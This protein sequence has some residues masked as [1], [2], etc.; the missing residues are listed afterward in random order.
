[1]KKFFKKSLFISAFLLVCGMVQAQS[2]TG[3]VSD[4]AGP[5]P[6]VNVAVKNSKIGTTTDLDGKFT[7]NNLPK[8]AVLSISYLGYTTQI[9]TVNSQTIIDVTL[10]SDNVDL[11][12]VVVV[13]FGTT[14]KKD[15]TGAIAVVSAKEFEGRANTGIGNALEGKVA[16]VQ[17][18]KP[19]GQPQAGY[20]IR[21]RGTSTITAG[22]E[23]LYILDGIPTTSISEIS[24]SD[25][26]TMTVLKD[27]SSAAIYGA[28]G[29]NGVILITTKRGG[30]QKTKVTLDTYVSSATVS[31]KLD[32]LD[33]TQYKA[34]M[35]EMGQTTDWSKYPYN[36]NWQDRVLRTAVS[37]NYALGVSGGDEKT[38]YYLSGTSD[39]DYYP[40]VV[41]ANSFLYSRSTTSDQVYLG[42]FNGNPALKLPFNESGADFSD[43]Y[44][45][46]S[47]TI[48]LS[49]TKSG[50]RGE[51]DLYLADKISGKKWSLNLYN[52]YINSVNNEL[53][54]CYS[55]L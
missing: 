14:K 34:L 9:I 51:Y 24:P 25:I 32:V 38:N 49:S 43:A 13:G 33:A 3:K 2:V 48:L 15:V 36:N 54:G 18:T 21:V 17:I 47:H 50:G 29:S 55:P 39:N 44:P 40:I 27:A 19:S 26:E 12:E 45:V 6:G 28:N 46:D 4:S 23:P 10:V 35:T 41:D 37:T 5:L 42:Y 16:G 1:M 22:A 31:E 7:L 30:N 20:T 52:P 53:G 11:K 8:D